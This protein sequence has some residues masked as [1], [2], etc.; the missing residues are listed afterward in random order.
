M[1]GIKWALRKYGM[2]FLLAI[3]L[4]GCGCIVWEKKEEAYPVSSGEVKEVEVNEEKEQSVQTELQEQDETGDGAPYSY[5]EPENVLSMNE[6][7]QL[8]NSAVSAAE[9]CAGYYSSAEPVNDN[10]DVRY[11]VM[12]LSERK[13]KEIVNLLGDNGMV[14]VSDDLNMRNFEKVEDFYSLYRMGQE[15]LVTIYEPSMDGTFSSRTFVYRQGILQTYYIGI[16][17]KKD[18]IPDIQVTRTNDIAEFRLTEKGYLIYVNAVI[19]AHGNLKEYYRVR[20]LPE[21]CREYTKKYVSGL[22]YV[23]YNVLI[24]DWDSRNV[25][26]I[27]RPCMFEDIYRIHTGEVFNPE[28]EGIPAELYEEIMTTY[29]PVTAEQLKEKCKYDAA[30]NTYKYEM[31]ISQPLPPFPEVVDYIENEDGTLTLFVDGVWP[32]Q[33]SDYAFTNQIVVRPLENGAFRYLSNTIQRQELDIP[34]VGNR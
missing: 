17:W 22:S 19:V 2:R 25:E 20:P 28:G 5:T 8:Q 24:T 29:F 21:I 11:A 7:L 32:D 13:R 10:G 4:I 23:S 30:A 9:M 31:S 16:G 6:Q 1:E 18:G 34:V 3:F 14:S 33:D 12:E 15:A 27:L 26:E